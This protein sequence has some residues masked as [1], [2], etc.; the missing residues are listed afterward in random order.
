MHDQNA[1]AEHD[2]KSDTLET[3][4]EAL[5]DSIAPD[6]VAALGKSYAD[7]WRPMSVGE[8]SHDPELAAIDEKLL[9][10]INIVLCETCGKGRACTP[11]SDVKEVYA[12]AASN[13]VPLQPRCLV[14][15]DSGATRHMLPHRAGFIELSDSVNGVVVLG[16]KSYKIDI[17]GEG[18]TR[19]SCL[20]RVLLVPALSM[21]LIS[22]G[23]L[24][25]DGYGATVCDGVFTVI[26]KQTKE[27]ALVA[28]RKKNNLYYLDSRFA[29]LLMIE[30]SGD[31][32]DQELEYAQP[33]EATDADWFNLHRRLGH[34]S[35]NKML[36]GL[37]NGNWLGKFDITYELA[38]V[39]DAAF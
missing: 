39:V 9:R 12:G 37:K 17:E 10:D 4:E 20:N 21:G 7:R 38:Q 22:M 24:D 3:S 31:E 25:R 35:Q 27:V 29:K 5:S 11:S 18:L 1:T 14:I 36:K 2:H 8:G 13:V 28:H 15:V 30:E 19:L 26:D 23:Q 32:E 33:A 16:K 6:V 34:L